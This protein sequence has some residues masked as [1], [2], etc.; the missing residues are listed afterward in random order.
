MKKRI[1]ARVPEPEWVQW[2]DWALL[3]GYLLFGVLIVLPLSLL[4]N[5]DIISE[6]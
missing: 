1:W 5:R 6:D 3:L 2:W 4:F